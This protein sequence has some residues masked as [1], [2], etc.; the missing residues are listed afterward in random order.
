[1]LNAEVEEYLESLNKSNEKRTVVL[2]GLA[3]HVCIKLTCFDLI[4][5][6]YKVYIVVDAV[7]SMN[8]SDRNVALEA[9][10]VAGANLTTFQSLVFEL[11]RTL[12]HPCFREMLKIIKDKPDDPLDLHYFPSLYGEQVNDELNEN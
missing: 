11:L 10:R 9:M 6:G 3:A 8:H 7:T 4:R 12:D 1:M 2:Y 5:K